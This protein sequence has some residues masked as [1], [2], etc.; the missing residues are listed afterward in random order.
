MGVMETTE[1]GIAGV[2][3]GGGRLVKED[4]IDPGVGFVFHKRT[5]DAV[6]AGEALVTIHYNDE[7]KL[8]VARERLE[9][10]I[11]V[12]DEPG[13]LGPLIYERIV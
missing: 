4:D 6:Q 9:A 5:G 3:L 8:A 1:I 7:A 13:E 11:P 12:E 10:A 2:E